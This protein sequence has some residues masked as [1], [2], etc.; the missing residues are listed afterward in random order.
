MVSLIFRLKSNRAAVGLSWLTG[1]C[2]KSSYNVFR[3]AGSKLTPCLVIASHFGHRQPIDSMEIRYR[4]CI[5]A[6]GGHIPY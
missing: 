6:R 5:Q 1:C 3:R 2:F 4:Q